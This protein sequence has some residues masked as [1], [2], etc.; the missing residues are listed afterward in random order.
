MAVNVAGSAPGVVTQQDTS[1]AQRTKARAEGVLRYV[2][3]NPTLLLGILLLLSLILF[4]AIGALLYDTARARPLS[5]VPS[6]TPSATYPFGSDNQGRDLF[7]VIILGVPLTM[8]V[9]LTAGII[10]VGIGTVLA[11]VS[12]Y[13]GGALDVLIR[14]VVDV[15]LTVPG[16]LV[17]V[18]IAV[19]VK[20]GLSV[21]QMALIIASLAWLWP[22]RTIRAQVLTMRGLGYVHVARLSGMSGPAIIFKEMLPNL[23]P[24]LGASLVSSTAAAVLASV[25]LEALGLGPLE[26]PTIGMTIYWVIYNSAL[27]HGMWWWFTPPLVVVIILF[28]G[29][30]SLS[31]G[32]DEVANPRLRQ[33]A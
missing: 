30:F 10:G 2:R 18:I 8:R 1:G 13:Y 32:L 29:L 16:L 21:D 6:L 12:A 5:V 4:S 7:A 9:G 14:G 27:L 26:S 15:G 33:S 11:F 28:L 22:T 31:A 17:L 19:M 24:Y 25:G 3:R 23:L 20:G